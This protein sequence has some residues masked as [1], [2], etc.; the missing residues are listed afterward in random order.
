MAMMTTTADRDDDLLD[1]NVAKQGGGGHRSLS[2]HGKV[3][4]YG[5]FVE[6]NILFYTYRIA[7]SAAEP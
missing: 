5:M 2:K 7:S 6:Y 1:E 4:F 3:G